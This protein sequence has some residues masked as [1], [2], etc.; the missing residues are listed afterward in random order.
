[1]TL[2]VAVAVHDGRRGGVQLELSLAGGQ[3]MTVAN[4]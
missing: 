3:G 1:M 4:S 2:V